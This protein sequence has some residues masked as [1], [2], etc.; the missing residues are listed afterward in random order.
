[1]TGTPRLEP[2]PA[3][4]WDDT[5]TDALRPL[6]SPAR[7][8]PHDAGNVLATLVHHPDLTRAYLTFNAHLLV[9]S[10]LPARVRE[11][12]LLRAVHVRRCDYLWDHHGPIAERAGM[13][14]AEIDA[15]RTDGLDDAAE[16]AVIRAVDELSEAN[17]LTDETWSALRGYFDEPQILDLI[18][19]V[20]CY[21]L[22]GSAVNALRIQ[23]EAH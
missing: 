5:V 16:R 18:F 2:L 8:N 22:L 15:V 4:R 10:T 11:V 1:M 6:L 9:T 14:P 7:M 17:T 19:T 23:P 12:A 13:T 3:D 21:Q 20:G